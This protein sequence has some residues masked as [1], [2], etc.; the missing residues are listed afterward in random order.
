MKDIFPGY[1]KKSDSEI[2]KIWDS[3][4][5]CFDANVLLNLYRYS[6]D[7]RKAILDLVK[8]FSSQICLPHQSALEYN[9]NRYEVIA[10]QEKAYKEFISKIGQIESDLQSTSKPPFLSD[11]LHSSLKKVFKEVNS[12]VEN[13]IKKYCDFLQNDTIYSDLTSIFGDKITSEFS[14]DDLQSI[15]D[16][17]EKRFEKKIPPGFEDEKTKQGNRKYGDLVL[18]KQ[19]IEKGKKEKKPIILITDERKKDWWWKIKDGRN[20]GPRQELVEE[21]K[22]EAEV[23]FH[24]YSSERFLSYGLDHLKERVNRKA[25]EEIKEIKRAEIEEIE[26]LKKRQY[27][28]FIKRKQEKVNRDRDNF[29]E[30]K[31]NVTQHKIDRHKHRQKMLEEQHF[32]KSNNEEELVHLSIDLKRLE[33]RLEDLLK[34][35]DYDE[36]KENNI[37]RKFFRDFEKDSDEKN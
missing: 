14:K 12:E 36:M 22:K 35:R 2:K 28:D 30:H 15:Y 4:I 26:R 33:E 17:G 16:E 32:D 5:I 31:I 11:K 20:M 24:M 18:W 3:G 27:N 10:D 9:R 7:T 25:L 1:S 6:N 21:M 19:I 37:I 13:S 34:K 29:L 8:K 23:E